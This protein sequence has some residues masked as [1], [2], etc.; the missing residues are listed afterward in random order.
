MKYPTKFAR[1]RCAASTKQDLGTLAGLVV[2][3]TYFDGTATAGSVVTGAELTP[4]ATN[5]PTTTADIGFG[6]TPVTPTS[7][8]YLKAAAVAKTV[9]L[10]EYVEPSAVAS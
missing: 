1:V 3:A 4:A 7:S 8:V 2:G 9:L 6:G 10:V 5:A